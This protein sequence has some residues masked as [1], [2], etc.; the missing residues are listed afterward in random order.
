VLPPDL[1]PTGRT[2]RSDRPLVLHRAPP[3]R[4]PDRPRV[5]PEGERQPGPKSRERRHCS[6]RAQ[7][8]LGS[9]GKSPPRRPFWER[10]GE[11]SPRRRRAVEPWPQAPHVLRG[12]PSRREQTP[13]RRNPRQGL[14]PAL[15]WRGV[16]LDRA[17]DRACSLRSDRG[18]A[19]DRAKSIAREIDSE[20]FGMANRQASRLE[21]QLQLLRLNRKCVRM[22]GHDSLVNS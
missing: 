9:P 5:P 20:A 17:G 7:R 12:A 18:A 21:Q 11:S 10:E 14:R 16:P 6:N 22:G 4:R 3:C 13:P 2:S 1:P 15:K 19:G 8:R